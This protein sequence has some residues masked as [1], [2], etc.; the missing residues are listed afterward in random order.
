MPETK[1][2][3]TPEQA[4]VE[5]WE[6]ETLAPALKQRPER[7]QKFET[8][9]LAPVNRLYTPADTADVRSATSGCRGGSERG[10]A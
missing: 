5:R 8:V 2:L 4:A 9:S 1:E 3:T 6:Q 10:G 7:K